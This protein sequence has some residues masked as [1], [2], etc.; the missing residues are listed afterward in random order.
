MTNQSTPDASRPF[1][2]LPCAFVD[3]PSRTDIVAMH[4][5]ERRS[6]YLEERD[7]VLH[8]EVKDPVVF[9]G[10]TPPYPFMK[11]GGDWSVTMSLSES[12]ASKHIC[13]A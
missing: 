13:S 11:R 10:E 6:S 7:F 9:K 3:S 2:N 5:L 8:G 4:V 12:P 1:P